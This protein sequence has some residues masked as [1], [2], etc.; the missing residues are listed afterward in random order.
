M[1]IKVLVCASWFSSFYSYP[2]PSETY[3]LSLHAALPICMK[4]YQ[5][6]RLYRTAGMLMR[7]GIPAVKALE[8]VEG[9]L[10]THLRSEEH[11]SELQSRFDL[12]CRLLLE[13]KK[14]KSSCSRVYLQTPT[15]HNKQR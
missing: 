11:T 5:L 1:L 13:K 15:T 7:A 12:V 10:A 4:T 6:A 9:L 2:P 3:T 8:M 14:Q